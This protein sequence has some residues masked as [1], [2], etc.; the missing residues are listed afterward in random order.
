MATTIIISPW[1][2]LQH[3]SMATT[4]ISSSPT[5]SSPHGH[6]HHLIT[7][8]TTISP[9]AQPWHLPM[10]TTTVSLHGHHHHLLNTNTT[11]SPWPPPSF[12]HSHHQSQDEPLGEPTHHQ[13]LPGHRAVDKRC[14]GGTKPSHQ[15]GIGFFFPHTQLT[16]QG[17]QLGIIHQ[18]RD[19]ARPFGLPALSHCC[20]SIFSSTRGALERSRRS[21]KL[22]G[23]LVA[24]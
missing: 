19:G 4:T 17:C 24:G 2:Q 21:P 14:H 10:A 12:L 18:G 23:V 1:P 15:A 20:W 7:T 22:C 8:T 6:S 9:S 11:V 13:P 5:P 16:Q 3:F